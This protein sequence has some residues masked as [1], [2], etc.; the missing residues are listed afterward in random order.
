[1]LLA[2]ALSACAPLQYWEPPEGSLPGDSGDTG[3]VADVDC[4][5]ELF[6][7]RD[8]VALDV[9]GLDEVTAPTLTAWW[10]EGRAWSAAALDAERD[11][12]DLRGLLPMA[13]DDSPLQQAE[14][15]GMTLGL[16]GLRGDAPCNNSIDATM[17]QLPATATWAAPAELSIAPAATELLPPDGVRFRSLDVR[18][19]TDRAH[20]DDNVAA[21][22][23]A[24][25]PLGDVFRFAEIDV[26]EMTDEEGSDQVTN[27]DFFEGQMLGA[28][29]SYPGMTYEPPTWSF[30]AD[31]AGTAS[32]QATELNLHNAYELTG[33]DEDGRLVAYVLDWA[34][35]EGSDG[36][37]ILELRIDPD[38]GEIDQVTTVLD[39]SEILRPGIFEHYQY[40]N[41]LGQAVDSGWLCATQR[42][43]VN[44]ELSAVL[45]MPLD[46]G[47]HAQPEQLVML[48]NPGYG[49]AALPDGFDSALPDAQLVELPPASTDP[50]QY[51][52][53]GP[54]AAYWV[55]DA[56]DPDRALFVGHMLVERDEAEDAAAPP[57]ARP[58][59]TL[60]YDMARGQD[61]QWAPTLRCTFTDDRAEHFHGS[62]VMPTGAP[63]LMGVY[64]AS[65]R[66]TTWFDAASCTRLGQLDTTIGEPGKWSTTRALDDLLPADSGLGDAVMG[67]RL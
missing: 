53:D 9:A 59:T 62:I 67:V 50:L 38:T 41:F 39:W 47:G 11:R 64:T 26:A 23:S 16:S 49:E 55:P 45:C 21:Y 2:G 46:E 24:R 13:F 54:H 63:E 60:L 20:L 30:A 48:T 33:V 51:A 4:G 8:R 12:F 17:P 28:T 25:S 3:A 65:T 18:V 15:T 58:T 10:Y 61:G 40:F 43:N 57:T 56:D 6:F 5:V 14:G 34:T 44:I 22:I 27:V 42:M 31:D 35:H 37:T 66:T 52:I 1:M 19:E 7:D 29:A 36:S 32:G